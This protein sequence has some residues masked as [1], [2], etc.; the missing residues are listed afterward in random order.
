MH[1]S[2]RRKKIVGKRDARAGN[3]LRTPPDLV[4]EQKKN[5]FKHSDSICLHL[6]SELQKS[7]AGHRPKRKYTA[8]I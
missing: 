7:P 8:E 1:Q 5:H 6:N 2:V 4:T 3:L